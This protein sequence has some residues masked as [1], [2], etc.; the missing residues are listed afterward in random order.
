MKKPIHK[1]LLL[2]ANINKFPSKD[3]EK[4]V[5]SFME[6]LVEKIQMKL[7]AGPITKFVSDQGNVGWTS[8]LLLSTSHMAM[9]I[10]N[11]WGNMQLDVYSCK[12]FDES[13]VI[14]H[15]KETFDATKIKYRILN[16]DGGLNDEAGLKIQQ[17]A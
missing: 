16:R 6:K 5:S 4:V 9:H 7:I 15:L 2:F 13:I 12:E 10:W 17:W 8:T 1:H 14:A 11:E 3:D